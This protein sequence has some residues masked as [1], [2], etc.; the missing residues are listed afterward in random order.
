MWKTTILTF[1]KVIAVD[2]SDALRVGGNRF[3][4]SEIS[5]TYAPGFKREILVLL[6]SLEMRDLDVGVA[7]RKT[8]VKRQGSG[9][10]F[11]RSNVAIT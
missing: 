7:W 11:I 4:S 8:R 9:P 6:K 1:L 3:R 5:L 2:N 10:I